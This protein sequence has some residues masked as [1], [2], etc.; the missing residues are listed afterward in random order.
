MSFLGDIANV[1]SGGIGSAIGGIASGVG[2]LIGGMNTNAA[3]A[4]IAQ[5]QMQFQADQSGTQ[6]QRAVKDMEAAGLSPMLAYSQGGNSAA[7]GASIAM[8]NPVSPAISSAIQ[9]MQAKANLDLIRSQEQLAKDQS[10]AA[11][12]QATKTSQET[13]N[14]I[15]QLPWN[16]EETISRIGQNSSSA[17]QLRANANY[18]TSMALGVDYENILK[19]KEANV[20]QG[21]LGLYRARARAIEDIKKGFPSLQLGPLGTIGIK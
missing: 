7:T 14:M 13:N 19:N 15:A 18:L 10:A 4:A 6:Y 16:I 8:Q 17:N 12:A 21:D 2:S 5:Q 20:N 11:I 3:N 9:G 1:F